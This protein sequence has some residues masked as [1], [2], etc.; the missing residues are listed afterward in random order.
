MFLWMYYIC[1]GLW[2]VDVGKFFYNSPE[3]S[4]QF[5]QILSNTIVYRA[6]SENGILVH[7]GEHLSKS[8]GEE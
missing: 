2:F 8:F 3:K 1:A 5:I 6:Y 4:G 7:V